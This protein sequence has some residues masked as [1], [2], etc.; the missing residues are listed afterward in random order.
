M[1]TPRYK[2]DFTTNCDFGK[3]RTYN[4][5]LTTFNVY[6]IMYTYIEGRT[7]LM[8]TIQTYGLLTEFY[9]HEFFCETHFVQCLDEKNQYIDINRALDMFTDYKTTIN[10]LL[11]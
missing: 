5:A 11:T 6:H 10:T 9:N 1:H 8:P 3:I 7:F 4:L 2:I